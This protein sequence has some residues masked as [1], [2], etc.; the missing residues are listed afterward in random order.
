MGRSEDMDIRLSDRPPILQLRPATSRAPQRPEPGA[1]LTLKSFHYGRLDDPWYLAHRDDP[2]GAVPPRIGPEFP[3]EAW[4]TL[5]E[6]LAQVR[7]EPPS[8][9]IET[10]AGIVIPMHE[11]DIWELAQRAVPERESRWETEELLAFWAFPDT[12][13]VDVG[14]WCLVWRKM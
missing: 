14:Q 5:H 12:P 4:P 6:L 10:D 1:P 3:N 8:G 9:M 2:G 11:R 7:R 13:E